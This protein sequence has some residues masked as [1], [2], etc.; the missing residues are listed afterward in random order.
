MKRIHLQRSAMK[1]KLFIV[2]LFLI[3]ST[4]SQSCGL[5]VV[6]E[7]ENAQTEA[8]SSEDTQTQ[9]VT[10]DDKEKPETSED[11]EKRSQFLLDKIPDISFEKEVI[12]IYTADDTFFSGDGRQT[13]LNS[14]RIARIRKV[15][16]KFDLTF[17]TVKTAPSAAFDEIAAEYKVGSAPGHIFA[18][19]S[20]VTASLISGGYL[21]SLRVSPYFDEDA[22]YFNSCASAFTLG[23]DIFAVSGDGCFEPNKL[24]ALYYNRS[25]IEKMGLESI[26]ELVKNGQWT[27]DKFYEYLTSASAYEGT[28]HCNNTSSEYTETLLISSFSFSE[29]K[30]DRPV[31][32]LSFDET[33]KNVCNGI[34]KLTEFTPVKN[35]DFASGDV[36]FMTDSLAAAEKLANTEDVWSIAPYPKCSEESQYMSFISKDAVVLSIPAVSGSASELGAVIM[37]LNAASSGYVIQKYID[38]NMNHF[39]RDNGAVTA[40]HIITKNINYDFSYIFSGSYASI[41]K[42][43]MSAFNSLIKQ[44][45]THEQYTEKY[46]KESGEYLDKHFPAKYY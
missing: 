5:I 30:I 3:I 6:N 35:G 1:I 15:E 10:E 8:E 45:I 27:L 12:T 17:R 42:Y 20:D 23:N 34:A 31:R 14:D 24:S 29:N 36:L 39:L 25:D 26:S 9:N 19:P 2:S 37:G 11:L 40:F 38:T 21:K 22:E 13:V 18:L 44:D 28:L 33:F 4:L 16:E 43:T 32:L 46:E 41:N 7:R